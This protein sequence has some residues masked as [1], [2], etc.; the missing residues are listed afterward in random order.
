M[1]I[2]LT[3][4]LEKELIIECKVIAA[5]EEKNLNDVIEEAM[6]ELIKSKQQK[7]PD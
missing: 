1:R 7:S 2:A 3:T 5:R 6:S 4:R